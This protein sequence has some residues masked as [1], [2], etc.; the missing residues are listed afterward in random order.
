[1]ET[2]D[3]NLYNVLREPFLVS[4]YVQNQDGYINASMTP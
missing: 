2:T 1:M 4:R 3:E